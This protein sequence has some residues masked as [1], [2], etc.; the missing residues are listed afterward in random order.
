MA[1]ERISSYVT[2]SRK[3]KM[4]A[5]EPDVLLSQLVDEITTPFQRLTPIFGVQ[6]FNVAI[7]NTVL[8]TSGLTAAILNFLLPVTSDSIAEGDIEF[9]DPENMG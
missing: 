1:L 3:S 6:E 7:P 9:S 5:A 2:G 8:F 4:A